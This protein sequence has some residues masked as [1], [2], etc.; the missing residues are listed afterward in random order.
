M[1]VSVSMSFCVYFLCVSVRVFCVCEPSFKV[2]KVTKQKRVTENNRKMTE[3]ISE[4]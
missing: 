1:C 3:I 4:G 2:L